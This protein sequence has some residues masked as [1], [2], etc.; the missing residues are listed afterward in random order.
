MNVLEFLEAD[1]ESRIDPMATVF[2]RV[3]K[4]TYLKYGSSGTVQRHDAICLLPVNSGTSATL[5]NTTGL[6]NHVYF[7]QRKDL[8]F[9]LV[10]VH[11]L[12]LDHGLGHCL[13]PFVVDSPLLNQVVNR[14]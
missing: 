13:S 1:P 9:P 12:G 5:M 6:N 14:Q 2:P 3:T 10:L 8:R 4:C 7:S 11:Y